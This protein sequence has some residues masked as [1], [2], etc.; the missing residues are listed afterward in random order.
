MN[1]NVDRALAFVM[2]VGLV[3]A[4]LTVVAQIIHS[5]EF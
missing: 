5:L 1:T 2:L 3:F 4:I